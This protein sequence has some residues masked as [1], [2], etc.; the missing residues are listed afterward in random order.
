MAR[1]RDVGR[2]LLGNAILQG[3]DLILRISPTVPTKAVVPTCCIH[4]GIIEVYVY[5]YTIIII[6]Y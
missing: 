2:C 4:Y 1:G 6:N 5:I 3:H